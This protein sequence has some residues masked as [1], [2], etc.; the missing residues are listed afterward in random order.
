MVP[1]EEEEAQHF[2]GA[3]I[4][5][6]LA[7]GVK[8]SS[9]DDEVCLG[10]QQTMSSSKSTAIKTVELSHSKLPNGLFVSSWR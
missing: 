2:N 10:F 1:E 4:A 3:P 8:A 7:G 9:R 6:Y 5:L